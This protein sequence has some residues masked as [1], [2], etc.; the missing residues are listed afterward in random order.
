MECRVCEKDDPGFWVMCVGCEEW[1]HVSCLDLEDVIHQI[2]DYFCDE[3]ESSNKG[4]T[5]WKGK[6]PTRREKNFKN[7]NYFEVEKIKEH[8][9]E[10]D[11]R[12]FLIEWKNC[13]ISKR[14][15]NNV[16]TWEPEEYLD[17]CLDLL[18]QYCRK[19]KLPYSKITA[20]L[21]APSRNAKVNRKNWISSKQLLQNF[22]SSIEY[23]KQAHRDIEIDLWRSF[24]DKDGIYFLPYDFHCF[25]LLYINAKKFAFIADGGNLYRSDRKLAKEIRNLLQIRL[26]SCVFDQQTKLDHCGSSAILIALE[27]LRAHRL[28]I[29]PFDIRANTA[30][31]KKLVKQLHSYPSASLELPKL[32]ERRK[33]FYCPHCQMGYDS[34]QRRGYFFHLKQCKQK[35]SF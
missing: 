28:E 14:N 31:K 22:K 30:L 19:N 1:W 21:G 20:L 10:N 3:C 15:K 9:V 7:E 27:F 6:R 34:K 35:R 18:Q 4:L 32:H 16:C 13:P 17:G 33:R 25:V 23:M 11:V 26:I 24:N 12:F 8:K 29:K 2:K 5:S